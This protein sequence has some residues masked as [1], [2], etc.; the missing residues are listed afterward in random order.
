MDWYQNTTEKAQLR[1]TSAKLRLDKSWHNLGNLSSGNNPPRLTRSC[2]RGNAIPSFFPSSV[3]SVSLEQ[4]RKP[5][6]LDYTCTHCFFAIHFYLSFHIGV[7][8]NYHLCLN[9]LLPGGNVMDNLWSEV[10]QWYSCISWTSNSSYRI[11]SW[12]VAVKLLTGEYHKT[13]M[14]S[15]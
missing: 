13:L 9:S 12:A 10:Y 6:Y 4:H 2:S 5:K 1:T 8:P 7:V 3:P 14:R 11:V 15:T